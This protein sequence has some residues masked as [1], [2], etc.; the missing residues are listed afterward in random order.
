[1]LGAI[2]GGIV[3]AMNAMSSTVEFENTNIEPYTYVKMETNLKL[4]S[5]LVNA[6]GIIRDEETI[7]KVINMFE[8]EPKCERINFALAML[9]SALNRKESR[10]AHYRSDY[11]KLTD[12]YKKTT[13]AKYVNGKIQIELRPIPKHMEEIY[14]KEN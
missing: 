3:A 2:Y 4:Q 7:L 8:N 6:L 11:P 10:G 1:M 5:S 13:I 12:E 14:E 9:Y